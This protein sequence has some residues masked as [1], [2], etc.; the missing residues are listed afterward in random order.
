MSG[1]ARRLGV[2]FVAWS[3]ALAVLAVA[4]TAPVAAQPAATADSSADVLFP[5][6]G[7]LTP[8]LEGVSPI[9]IGVG[10]LVIGG[11]AAGALA[12]GIQR[13]SSPSGRN[14]Q[15][16]AE[17][18]ERLAGVFEELGVPNPPESIDDQ[19]ATLEDFEA[20]GDLV[21][22]PDRPIDRF[23]WFQATATE[24]RSKAPN[25]SVASS[26]L[27]AI[28][29]FDGKQSSKQ[30]VQKE[31]GRLVRQESSIWSLHRN[32]ETYHE[33]YDKRP[34]PNEHAEVTDDDF[35]GLLNSIRLLE[36]EL[37]TSGSDDGTT[38]GYL[39]T[40]LDDYEHVVE[41]YQTYRAEQESEPRYLDLDRAGDVAA[42]LDPQ[43][44]T[45]TKLTE[46]LSGE[47]QYSEVD[48]VLPEA[49]SSLDDH[50]EMEGALIV[51][52]SQDELRRRADAL[53]DDID[54]LDG[55]VGDVIDDRLD[56][57][58]FTVKAD[59]SLIDRYEVTRTLTILEDIVGDLDARR[60][61]PG[62]DL[63]SRIDTLGADIQEI[64]ERYVEDPSR[65]HYNHMIPLQFLSTA[66]ALHTRAT[67]A[68]T[69]GDTEGAAA[70]VTAG[71]RVVDAVEELYRKS[72]FNSLLEQLPT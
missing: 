15:A 54:R 34:L 57:V 18:S 68:A 46:I 48:E 44:S 42:D 11:V 26:L 21:Y 22:A 6:V 19:I 66:E 27:A 32:L 14:D 62:A 50:H 52:E 35:D 56:G 67:E 40:L 28:E 8:F 43:S 69:G 72:T 17:R 53:H 70:Y 2:Q 59:A 29:G 47:R 33:A 3:A 24:F 58:M 13:S 36:K 51:A 5:I 63:G 38:T 71:E 1:D 39:L 31:L 37:D 9:A 64:R 41:M 12:Y 7:Q 10:G 25:K 30:S 49:V 23:E 61:D 45:A 65:S 20:D 16:A 60:T 4:S 55:V